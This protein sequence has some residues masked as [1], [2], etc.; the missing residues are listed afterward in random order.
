MRL[1]E[2]HK[3]L[4]GIAVAAVALGASVTVLA[5][6]VVTVV[7]RDRKFQTASV[8]IA[9]GDTIRFTNED[10]FIHQLYTEA[11]GFSFSSAEQP[12]G[13]PVDVVFP[14]A[15]QYQVLCKIHPRMLLAVNVR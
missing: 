6:E 1:T 14:V 10:S 12:T 13:V 11:P 8:D 9:A 2:V 15:G 5:A 4:V 7:Q 3:E